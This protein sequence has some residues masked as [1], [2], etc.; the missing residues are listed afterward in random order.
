MRTLF[1]IVLGCALTIGAVYVA[2]RVGSRTNN[3]A[4]VNWDIV[5]KNVDEL[6]TLARHGW[7]RIAG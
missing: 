3:P 2:D 7:R 5:A 6:A 4:M 1:G